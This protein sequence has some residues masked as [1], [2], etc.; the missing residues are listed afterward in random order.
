MVFNS[1]EYNSVVLSALVVIDTYVPHSLFAHDSHIQS[2]IKAHEQTHTCTQTFLLT[3]FRDLSQDVVVSA[4][5]SLTLLNCFE[6]TPQHCFI[7]FIICFINHCT[8]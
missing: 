1:A 8:Q 2:D 7:V 4:D 6:I 3:V 5:A